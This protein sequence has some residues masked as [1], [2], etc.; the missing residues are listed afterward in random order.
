MN[1]TLK[2]LTT[3]IAILVAVGSVVTAH[4]NGIQASNE[5]TDRKIQE[6]AP[7]LVEMQKSLFEIKTK[8]AV[9]EEKVLNQERREDRRDR[10]KR[11][12]R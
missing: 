4:F 2:N 3:L 9:I 10:E 5:Y 8:T 6:I 7:I 12:E 1:S 11:G